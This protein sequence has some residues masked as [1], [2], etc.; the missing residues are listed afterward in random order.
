MLIGKGIHL[1]FD[2]AEPSLSAD[3]RS[4]LAENENIGVVSGAQYGAAGALQRRAFERGCPLALAC[5]ARPSRTGRG[6][7]REIVALLE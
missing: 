7:I 5:E 4:A 1:A 6:L 3:I 2:A